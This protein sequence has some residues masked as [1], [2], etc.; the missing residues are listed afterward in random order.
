MSP[1]KYE[2]MQ[3]PGDGIRI[4]FKIMYSGPVSWAQGTPFDPYYDDLN[5]IAIKIDTSFKTDQDNFEDLIQWIQNNVPTKCENITNVEA[6]IMWNNL[7][8]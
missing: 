2:T 1:T 4:F 5:N 7:T 3:R 8:M 6:D